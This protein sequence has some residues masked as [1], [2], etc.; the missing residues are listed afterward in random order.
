MSSEN[1]HIDN[2]KKEMKVL[3]THTHILVQHYFTYLAL[4]WVD[5]GGLLLKITVDFDSIT[6]ASLI[7]IDGVF[8]YETK[9]KNDK[10]ML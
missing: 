1:I 4:F 6:N 3:S 2:E 9:K 10:H 8:T 5:A 7:W